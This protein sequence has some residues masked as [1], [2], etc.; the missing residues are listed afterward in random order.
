MSWILVVQEGNRFQQIRSTAFNFPTMFFPY[1]E[2][3]HLGDTIGYQWGM[4]MVSQGRRII[5]WAFSLDK[6]RCIEKSDKVK[7]KIKFPSLPNKGDRIG[8]LRKFCMTTWAGI[9]ICPW[10]ISL[11]S[12]SFELWCSHQRKG[13]L[14]LINFLFSLFFGLLYKAV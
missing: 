3:A 13:L 14:L 11:T 1:W 2:S 9:V 6:R 7:N 8:A 12:V 4:T 10:G 5:R